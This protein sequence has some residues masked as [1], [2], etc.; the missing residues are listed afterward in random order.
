MIAFSQAQHAEENNKEQQYEDLQLEIEQYGYIKNSQYQDYRY[1]QIDMEANYEI[2]VK[3]IPLRG[4]PKFYVKTIDEGS[5]WSARENNFHY[6][7]RPDPIK[8]E[9]QQFMLSTPEQ[10]LALWPKCDKIQR[11][12]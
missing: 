12:L 5:G 1:L 6:E 2:R 10:R 4:K 3:R 8:N 9:S 11:S 7:S